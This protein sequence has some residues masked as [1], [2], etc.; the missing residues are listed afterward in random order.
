MHHN[1]PFKY[2]G[3]KRWM[4][5]HYPFMRQLMKACPL[6]IEPFGGSLSLVFD[7]GKDAP[8]SVIGERNGNLVNYY[9]AA[10]HS[11]QAMSDHAMDRLRSSID[12][13]AV[14]RKCYD[15]EHNDDIVANM[16]DD[17]DWHDAKHAGDF[18]YYMVNC[19]QYVPMTKRN[20]NV[21]IDSRSWDEAY[22]RSRVV[23]ANEIMSQALSRAQLLHSD[24]AATASKGIAQWRAT[25]GIHKG[26]AKAVL[27]LDPPY[28]SNDSAKKGE[29]SSNDHKIYGDFKAGIFGDVV[30]WCKDNVPDSEIMVILCGNKPEGVDPLEGVMIREDIGLNSGHF[31]KADIRYESTWWSPKLHSTF[32]G[33]LI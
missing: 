19:M 18:V 28:E 32:I 7:M 12:L 13:T 15:F 22:Y 4:W 10:K 2:M 17:I 33:G 24:W 26:I 30:D 1:K 20:I 8:Q 25:A 29:K 14:F 6:W 21:T 23:D 5:G 16:R 9:R 27:F 11:H 3:S 31:G